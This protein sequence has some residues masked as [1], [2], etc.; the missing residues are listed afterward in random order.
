MSGFDIGT[1]VQGAATAGVPNWLREWQQHGLEAF[2]K[3]SW[4]TRK[5]EAWKYTPLQSLL[6]T[7]WSLA[8][9]QSDFTGVQLGDAEIIRLD[10]VNGCLRAEQRLPD[11][12]ELIAIAQADEATGERY[13]QRLK[14][15]AADA[16]FMSLN[17]A[18]LTQGYWLRVA[19]K[20][21]IKQPIH[22]NYVGAGN[23][24]VTNNQ[25]LLDVGRSAEVTLIETFTNA[26]DSHL[27][28]NAASL[29][30][31]AD[32]ARLDHYHLLLEQGDVRHI[33]Q[34]SAELQRNAHLNSFHLAYGGVLKRTDINLR[35]VGTGASLSLNGVY[36][37]SGRELVDY[38]TCIEHRVPHCES[39]EI[40][41][42]IIGDKAKAVFNGRIHIH[43]D[44]QKSLAELSNKNL[45]TSHDAE[46]DTKPELEIYADDVRCAH[47]ATVAQL[48]QAALH[49]CQA[50]GLTRANAELMLSAGFI[51]EL[52]D[53]VAVPA[54]KLYLEQQLALRAEQL[55]Q[56]VA[57]Q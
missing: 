5:S 25:L 56:E 1:A 3:D 30:A 19:D 54:V 34:L 31:L 57:G 35:H 27:L 23:A 15:L 51:N 4:P 24:Q 17:Q 12:V 18:L 16:Y 28:V 2:N 42:G 49:Y 11:G 14:T 36:L 37:P 32:D 21:V 29:I 6:Q 52:I 38:H 44:A 46:I 53:G 48:D 55:Q 7:Q 13:L 10:I 26:A 47:G 22:L 8:T 45:L 43:Q 33:G 40:F 20:A 41:R 9:Q 50:R 39:S